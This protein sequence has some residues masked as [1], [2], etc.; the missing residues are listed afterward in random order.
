MPHGARA[1]ALRCNGRKVL[2]VDVGRMT[3]VEVEILRKQ[4]DDSP[5]GDWPE[6]RHL[7]ELLTGLAG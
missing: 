6:V 1:W 7:Q 5:E 4:L 2:V 3:E